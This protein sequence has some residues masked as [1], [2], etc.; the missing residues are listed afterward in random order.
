MP[1]RKIKKK[2]LGESKSRIPSHKTIY[3]KVEYKSK[4]EADAAE[5]LSSN[6]IEFV[7]EGATFNVMPSFIS[8]VDCYAQLRKK[9]KTGK[10][11]KFDKQPA[12]VEAITYTPDFIH[13]N[14]DK[15]GWVIETKGVPNESFPLRFKLF[16]KF[17]HENGYNLTLFIPR[18][19][20]QIYK[21]V[22]IIKQ[23]QNKTK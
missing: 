4:L 2:G 23:N 3:G 20:E 15:T 17:L 22:E 7:Y 14:A 16:K 19:K 10:S 8:K 18:N 11:A 1:I 6:G 13:I 21:C 9:T 12:K 5:I